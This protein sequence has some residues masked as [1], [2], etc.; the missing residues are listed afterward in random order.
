VT[1]RSPVSRPSE[2]SLVS[3][4]VEVEVSNLST[5]T[6]TAPVSERLNEPTISTVVLAVESAL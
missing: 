5:P 1:D 3:I 6:E 4:S 2:A